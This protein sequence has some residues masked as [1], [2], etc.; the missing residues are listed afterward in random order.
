MD[1][2]DQNYFQQLTK[3]HT[4]LSDEYAGL[5]QV[6]NVSGAPL[7]VANGI[8][9]S[10]GAVA[11]ISGNN[12]N[13]YKLLDAKKIKLRPF[14]V[15]NTATLDIPEQMPESAKKKRKSKKETDS[16]SPLPQ[17][18]SVAVDELAAVFAT[19]DNVDEQPVVQDAAAENTETTQ[20]D[21]T[22]G[23]PEDNAESL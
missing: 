4:E 18:P 5:I 11:L 2:L 1:I 14:T 21:E 16:S 22:K 3:V 6:Q 23:L 9:M 15:S 19:S 12:P 13:L 8:Y 7:Q 20:I 10:P 17:Q